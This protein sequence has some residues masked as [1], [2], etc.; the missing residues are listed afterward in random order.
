MRKNIN[1][2]MQQFLLTTENYIKDNSI[3]VKTMIETSLVSLGKKPSIRRFKN[4]DLSEE[5]FS[6]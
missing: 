4:L 3:I 5:I 6:F 2:E 1:I